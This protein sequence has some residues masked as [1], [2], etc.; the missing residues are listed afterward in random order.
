MC[1]QL[2]CHPYDRN[3]LISVLTEFFPVLP[4]ESTVHSGFFVKFNE[5]MCEYFSIS[6]TLL[7]QFQETVISILIVFLSVK[8]LSFSGVTGLENMLLCIEKSSQCCFQ[9]LNQLDK[10]VLYVQRG[11]CHLKFGLSIISP[12]CNVT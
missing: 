9:K 8:L 4:E 5:L 6:Y 10:S 7:G 3:M 12:I 2:T 1:Q 11:K